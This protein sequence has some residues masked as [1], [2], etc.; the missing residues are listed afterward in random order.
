MNSPART[1]LVA[2]AL[3]LELGHPAQLAHGG[4]AL[5]QPGQSGVLGDVALDE[6]GAALRVEPDGEEVACGI[7]RV[8][9][10]HGRVDLVGEGVQVDHAVEGVAVVLEG[11]PVPEGPEVVAEGEVARGGDAGQDPFHG[12]PW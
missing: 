10:E 11:H 8:A 5:E 12:A 1:D 9:P 7:E 2:L 6:D 3:L 4:G